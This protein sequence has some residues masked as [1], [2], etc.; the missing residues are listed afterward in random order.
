MT[1]ASDGT[2]A[3]RPVPCAGCSASAPP[4]CR[5][6][7]GITGRFDA[8]TPGYTFIGA[9]L[10]YATDSVGLTLARNATTFASV[11]ATRN[12]AATGGAIE[13]LGAGNALYETVLVNTDP[14]AA[15]SAF[16]SLSGE[17]HASAVSAQFETA[18]FV[19]EAIL[20]RLRRGDV[21]GA[22][23][24]GGLSA[25]SLPAAY[26]ADLP[27]RVAPPV[28]VPAQLA[29]PRAYGLWGQGFGAFGRTRGDGNAASLSRQISGFVLGADTGLDLGGLPA[30]GGSASRA[31]TPTPAST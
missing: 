3:S 25:P 7:Q 14:A 29:A 19:R 1:V 5:P 23:V 21:A 9:N 27:G 30:P 2:T 4:S 18:F 10:D 20:D 8:A 13:A 22:P 16:A 26:S 12:Q 17:V 11:G 28:Q 24:F 31:A 15:R 6:T